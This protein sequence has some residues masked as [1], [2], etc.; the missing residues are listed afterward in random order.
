[1]I[2]ED[3]MVGLDPVRLARRAGIEPD[4]WQVDVLR[5]SSPRLLL[6]CSRQSGK[7]TVTAVLAVHTAL[8]QPGA[9]VLLLSRA[10][11]QS[12]ELFRKCLDVYRALGR[13]VPA[14]SETALTLTL[15]NGS[16][17]VS[18]PGNEATVRGYAGAALI[19]IDE[20]AR[21]L[22]PLYMS[23]RPM[24]AVSG[25][26]LI[27]LS[28]PWGQRGFFHAEWTEGGPDWERVKITAD[29]CPRISTEFIEDERRSMPP[30]WFRQEYMVSF[31]EN[32]DAV[33]PYEQ[34]MAALDDTVP[35]LLALVPDATGA[36]DDAVPGLLA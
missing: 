4:P 5:S 14:D 11:R 9:L 29:Q 32:E 3:L 24:L 12:Q 36:L 33:F 1:M 10:L 20:A 22:D 2:A 15:E 35:P 19:A 18:L 17:I 31:E 21:V 26:R 25:G 13:P 7:S 23:V 28:T 27:A 34:V 6:L 8:F 30:R 16:R